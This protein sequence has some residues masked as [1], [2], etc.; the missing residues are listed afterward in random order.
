MPL[1]IHRSLRLAGETSEPHPWCATVLASRRVLPRSA[2]M[3]TTSGAQEAETESAG[4]STT[5]ISGDSA[6]PNWL[7]MYSN[8]LATVSAKSWALDL[9]ASVRKTCTLGASGAET[10][11]RNLPAT[12]V[13][14]KPDLVQ[15]K[16]NSVLPPAAG[17]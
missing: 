8:S 6:P 12:I 17:C 10:G 13:P 14:G 3:A 16:M 15:L 4:S 11:G 5:L 2:R 1:V 7:V 9:L